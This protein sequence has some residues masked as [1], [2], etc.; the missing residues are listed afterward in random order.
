MQR[1]T[2]RASNRSPDQKPKKNEALQNI[3][4]IRFSYY[5]LLI[6]SYITTYHKYTV[7]IQL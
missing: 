4:T 7:N 1:S 5:S 2:A 6:L 3:W